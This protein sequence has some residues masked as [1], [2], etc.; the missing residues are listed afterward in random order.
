MSNTMPSKEEVKAVALAQYKARNR[1]FDLEEFEKEFS[2]FATVRKMISRFLKSDELNE[3]YILNKVIVCSNVF[4]SEL[5]ET[6]FF[7]ICN[8]I[9]FSVV[10]ACMVYQRLYTFKLNENIDPHRIMND[11]LRDMYNRKAEPLPRS[12]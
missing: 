4:G 6:I 11:I 1:F 3:K 10:K 12:F 2:E 5:A 7:V 8:P 9:Q